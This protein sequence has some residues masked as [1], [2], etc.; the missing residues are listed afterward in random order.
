MKHP[1]L[2]L[3][4]GALLLGAKTASAEKMDSETQNGVI[5]RLERVLSRMDRADGAYAPSTLRLADLLSERARLRAMNEVEAGCQGCQGSGEDRKKALKMYEDLLPGARRENQGAILFQMAHLY[6]MAGEG[7]KAA[8]LF[9][10]ILKEPKKYPASL[11]TQARISYSDTL[12]AKG[13]FKRALSETETVFKDEKSPNRGLMLYRIAW[14]QF[15]LERLPQ[16]IRSLEK[17]ASSPALLMKDSSRGPVV[18][19]AFQGDVLRDLG[20]FYARQTVTSKEIDRFVKLLPA[21]QRKQLLLEF[22]DEVGRVGQKKSA[23]AIYNIYLD[24]PGLTEDERLRGFMSLTQANFDQGQSGRSTAD[25][26]VAAKA[27]KESRCSDEAQCVELKKQMKRYVTEL[28]RS[29]KIKPDVDVLKAYA[30]YAKTFPEDTEMVI[31][32]AQVAVDLK[33]ANMAAILYRHAGDKAANEKLRETALLGEIDSAEKSGDPELRRQAYAHYLQLMPNGP[34]AFEV[35]YQDAR[36]PYEAKQWKIA[37]EKFRALALDQKGPVSLR[38]KSADLALDSL[39]ME[40]RDADLEAWSGEFARAMPAAGAEYAKISR[41]AVLNQTAA[42]AN[43]GRSSGS[44][45]RAALQKMQSTSLEGASDAEKIPHYKNQAILAE[46][47]GDEAA[48][49]VSL[50]ALLAVK[51]LSAEDR[52]QTLAREVG[53]FE[54]RLEFRAAYET[55][56]KMK[57][58]SLS[59]GERELRLATLADLGGMKSETHYRNAVKAGLSKSS[60]AAVR[61]RLVAISARP[62]KELEAQKKGLAKSP[63]VLGETAVLVYA[64]TRDAGALEKTLKMPVLNKSAAAKFVRK[65]AFYPKHEALSARIAN[66]VLD[67]RTEART[68]SSIQARVKLLKDAD[69]SLTEAVALNDFTAQVMALSTV[70]REND[71]LVR[72][73]GALPMPRGLTQKEQNQYLQLL[74]QQMRPFLVKSKTATQKATEFWGND[75]AVSS[76]LQELDRSRPEL[77]PLLAN[78]VRLLAQITPFNSVKSRLESA[79]LKTGPE[80]QELLSARAAV[81]NNPQ[82]AT[83]IERLKALETKI[84]H[85]LMAAYLEGRLGRIQKG[86]TL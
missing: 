45:L 40:K 14:C 68:Q 48:L 8:G 69:R 60:E 83:R 50:E 28:H 25:F 21:D 80:G 44:A 23:S 26:A 59:K 52:E 76:L 46:K 79:L 72:E 64:K 56:V 7:D 41:S 11:V 24:S 81:R 39:A 29:K 51:S 58:P 85:P 35:R 84:G 13:D 82:D 6:D 33:Q 31:R 57:F 62:L 34:K 67:S 4:L 65:Q 19:T 78:E 18:D 5:Q 61:A 63:A 2:P 74:K 54:R 15:N 36:L 49:L 16:A 75:R 30:I 71:R 70:A 66:H 12:F 3:I 10:K 27:Y 47:A 73:L 43:D 22:G 9:E 37:S 32:G 42:V 1:L 38:K 20:V 77:R 53:L 55:A 86:Q 17:L